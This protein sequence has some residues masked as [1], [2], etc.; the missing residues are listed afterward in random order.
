[1]PERIPTTGACE[2]FI[3]VLGFFL[4]HRGS[5]AS[6][7]QK[8][9]RCGLLSPNST[10][11]SDYAMEKTYVVVDTN[12][13]LH[14]VG[15]DQI[16]WD[17]LFPG[18][19]V[20]LVICPQVIRELNRHKDTPRNPKMRDR[21]TNALRKIQGWADSESPVSLK[22]SVEVQ[23]RIYDASIDFAAFRLVREVDDDHIIAVLIE[24]QSELPSNPVVLL[25]KD[26]GLKLKA[27]AQGF[28]VVSL[29]DSASL[30]EEILPSE[31]KIKELENQVKELQNIRPKLRLTFADGSSK[32]SLEF[33]RTVELS[34]ANIA[35]SVAAI[36]NK[37]PK[38]VE[39]KLADKADAVFP[40]L[41]GLARMNFELLQLTPKKIDEYNRSLDEFFSDYEQYLKDVRSFCEWE[42]RTA[43]LKIFLTNE[44]TCPA[45]DIDIFMHF[46]DGFKL[47]DEDDY[48][49]PPKEP[50]APSKPRSALDQLT[51]PVF[52]GGMGSIYHNH[53]LD[54]LARLPAGPSN[55]GSPKI[56][57]TNSYD[58]AVK[59]K[60]AKHGLIVELDAMYLTFDSF[61]TVQNF[62]IDYSI[63]ASNLPKH[64]EGSLNVAA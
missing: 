33:Q 60:K 4:V 1:M 42:R 59:V 17:D 14:F 2:A 19:M 29:P 36:R 62:K 37:Y 16:G 56:K 21:A 20:A 38:L 9:I 27:R 23:F 28:S 45:D 13:F 30:P 57:R 52:V 7:Q 10:L 41:Q 8:M 18:Q 53:N 61:S 49:E 47:F 22:D 55:V 6:F 24:M 12:T 39:Q 5:L 64:F 50:K 35:G 43:T 15:F 54:L 58:V 26:I 25:S 63:H 51:S 40:V 3:C 11:Y 34:E 46:P 31:K 32:V 44:G 48:L